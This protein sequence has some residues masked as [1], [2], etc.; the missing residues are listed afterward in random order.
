MTRKLS[1]HHLVQTSLATMHSST[2]LFTALLVSGFCTLTVTA[3]TAADIARAETVIRKVLFISGQYEGKDLVLTPPVPLADKSGLYCEPYDAQGELTPWAKKAVEATVGGMAGEKAGGA[4][5]SALGGAI[6]GAGLLSPFAKKKGKEL[7]AKAAV[8]GAEFIK[9]SST[10][11][12]NSIEDYAVFLHARFST[13][14]T[15][16]QALASTISVYPE[17]ETALEPAIKAAYA[18]A[19]QVKA[20]AEKQAAIKLAADKLV[21]E[22]AAADKAAAEKVAAAAAVIAPVVA[23]VTAPV[24]Q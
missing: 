15:Y 24:A 7:G 21:A 16:K 14:P 18:K 2:R 19:A 1:F 9:S 3:N 20:E 11:S 8:G 12:F 10:Y 5:I 6:P 4:A 22:K 17:L 13:K 23:P